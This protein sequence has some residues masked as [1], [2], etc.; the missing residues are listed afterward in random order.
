MAGSGG[1]LLEKD[2]RP[3]QVEQGRFLEKVACCCALTCGQGSSAGKGAP[4]IDRQVQ[5]PR[6]RDCEAKVSEQHARLHCTPAL[7]AARFTTARSGSNPSVRRTNDSDR[8]YVR[9]AWRNMVQPRKERSA[10]TC[11]SVGG[12]PDRQRS[13]GGQTPAVTHR[14]V[15][16]T[17]TV[18]NR[19]LRGDGADGGCQGPREGSGERLPAARASRWGG[20]RVPEL[21]RGAGCTTLWT[22]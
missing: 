12:L 10:V 4:G 5:R 2:L 1:N 8:R 7:T 20:A 16:L 15:P 17:R 6:G 3:V 14:P 19:P 11:R 18:E 22:C 9:S 21:S 13:A